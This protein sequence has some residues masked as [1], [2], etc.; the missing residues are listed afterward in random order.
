MPV[1]FGTDSETILFCKILCKTVFV[2]FSFL[3]VLH[4]TAGN[5]IHNIMDVLS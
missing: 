3:H 1:M 5:I 4:H 2:L